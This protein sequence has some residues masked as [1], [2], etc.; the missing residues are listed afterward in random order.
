MTPARPRRSEAGTTL[1]E[2][3]ITVMILGV[4]FVALLGGFG[5]SIV[6][7]DL[8]RRQAQAETLVRRYAEAVKAT[9][10]TATCPGSYAAGFTLPSGFEAPAA[11]VVCYASDNVAAVPCPTDGIQRVTVRV[12]TTDGRVDTSVDLVKRLS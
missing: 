5:T 10:C 3:L 4:A 11:T 2:V 1:V 12:R 8:H 9:P 6:S 7:S